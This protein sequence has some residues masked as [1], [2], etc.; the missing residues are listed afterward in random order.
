[1]KMPGDLARRIETGDRARRPQHARLRVGRK[2]AERIGDRTDQRV[3]EERRRSRWRAPSSTSAAAAH[4]RPRGRRGAWRRRWRDRRCRRR[5][6]PGPSRGAARHRHRSVAPARGV[7]RRAAAPPRN[8]PRAA[9]RRFRGA[10]VEDRVADEPGVLKCSS[11]ANHSQVSCTRPAAL[12]EEA[13]AGAVDHDA[14][15]ID[16]HDRCRIARCA[17]RS[18][19]HACRSSRRRA[20]RSPGAMRCRRRC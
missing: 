20:L 7:N 8:G 11:R 4:G 19:R 3:G 14:I 12:V 16:Q 9:S 10:G 6:R 13:A 17:H 1:M 18:A 5:C 2:A 15:G